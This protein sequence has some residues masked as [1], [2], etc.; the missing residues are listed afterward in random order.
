MKKKPAEKQP[1]PRMKAYLEKM[2]AADARAKEVAPVRHH[3]PGVA[4]GLDPRR[5]PKWLTNEFDKVKANGKWPI[6]LWGNVGRGKTFASAYFYQN[7]QGTAAWM[8]FKLF[9]DRT[10]QLERDGEITYYDEQCQFHEHSRESWW[11]GIK[12]VELLVI[13]D[14]GV[15]QESHARTE[16]LWTLLDARTR[17]PLV[18]T[19]NLTLDE[20]LH[21]FDGRVFSRLY[22]GTEIELDG[23]DLRTEGHEIRH[24]IGS[25]QDFES[26]DSY[27]KEQP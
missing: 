26:D 12:R 14:V 3:L 7:W 25:M 15:G 24:R 23:T 16:A 1:D 17:L 18:L 22:A 21:R 20:I 13:D 8:N 5:I 2:R 10:A 27:L 19:G 11:G 9:C 6:Y 4:L